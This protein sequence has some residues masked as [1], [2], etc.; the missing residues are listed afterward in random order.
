[1][2]RAGTGIGYTDPPPY[3]RGVDRPG[4]RPCRR[5]HPK[6][7]AANGLA[8]EE[9]SL[10][11]VRDRFPQH[12]HLP[13]HYVGL[14]DA[15]AGIV[16]PEAAITESL[17]L[18]AKDGADV[19]TGTRV[20]LIDDDGDAVLLRT[21]AGSVRARHVVVASG[22]WMRTLL[23]N[24]PVQAVRNPML[25]FDSPHPQR[26]TADAFPAFIRH[27]DDTHTL[28]GHGSAEGR[29]V[30]V[31]LSPDA[32]FMP[33]IDIDTID[34]G[35]DAERDWGHLSRVLRTAI[36]ELNPIPASAR[37]CVITNSPDGQ[38]LVG[39]LPARPRITIAGGCSG[40]GFKHASAIGEIVAR[41]IVGEQQSTDV[42][43]LSPARFG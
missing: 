28:W 33:D 12:A 25:W 6:A 29:P 10:E 22:P 34:R 35:V 41:D 3:R 26:F 8:V 2:G 30:K 13:D 32:R 27:Y 15:E 38:F 42:S 36:P 14:W 1:M 21:G 17:R 16:R 23:P 40:H 43:F 24:V 19:R 18:A 9:L 7:A 31:G 20:Q 11:Q 37:P 5:W 4:V 39:R